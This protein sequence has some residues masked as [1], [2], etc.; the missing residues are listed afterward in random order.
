MKDISYEIWFEAENYDM[1]LPNCVV[2]LPKTNIN[3][4]DM[5]ARG[6]P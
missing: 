3:T 6:F 5:V 1:R 4:F 2:V